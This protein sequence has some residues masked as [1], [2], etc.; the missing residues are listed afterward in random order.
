MGNRSYLYIS[1]TDDFIPI[2][3]SNSDIPLL[4]QYLLAMDELN[5]ELKGHSLANQLAIPLPAA[6]ERANQILDLI[7]QHPTGQRLPYLAGHAQVLKAHLNELMSVFGAEAKL[8]GNFDEIGWLEADC[9]EENFTDQFAIRLKAEFLQAWQN[10]E[11]PLLQQDWPQFDQK[12]GMPLT[13]STLE[14]LWQFWQFSFGLTTFD[15][16]KLNRQFTEI[17]AQYCAKSPSST[18][19]TTIGGKILYSLF[20]AVIFGGLYWLSNDTA[21]L[22]YLAVILGVLFSAAAWYKP[23][24]N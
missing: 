19:P 3:E 16:S 2:A 24:E 1:T 23:K 21:W 9:D 12:I 15:D 11:G 14:Q 18:G 13:N 20:W 6:I 22:R 10:I 7:A 4:W 5:V 8:T 17:F